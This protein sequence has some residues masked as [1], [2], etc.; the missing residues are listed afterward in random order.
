MAPKHSDD[1]R[2]GVSPECESVNTPALCCDSGCTVCVLDYP[3]LFLSS[4][5]APNLEAH[6]TAELLDAIA[7]AD[8]LLARLEPE[9]QTPNEGDH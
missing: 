4:P 3:D 7:L 6:E 8:Q 2:N 5:P 1:S 9:P